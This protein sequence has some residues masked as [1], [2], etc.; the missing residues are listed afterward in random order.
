MT[1]S[2]RRS[3]ILVPLF[4]IPSSC[5]WGIGDIG[6]VGPFASWLVGA[7][8]RILQFLPLNEMAS[9]A[10]SP[11]SALS[12]MAIDPIFI[13]LP[14]VPDFRAVGGLSSLS[15]EER[16]RLEFARQSSRVEYQAIRPIKH[17]AL[18]LAFEHFVDREWSAGSTRAD[19]LREYIAAEAWWLDDYAVFRALH[20]REQARPW[21]EWPAE[22]RQRSQD[23]MTEVRR[24]LAGE[25][26]FHQYVQ[27]LASQQ[28]AGARR[29]A[30]AS[31]VALF[32]DVP[33]MVDLHSADVWA[34]QSS[35][36]LDRSV[37]VPPDAFSADGQDWGMPAYNWDVLQANR[38]GWLRERARRAATL[39]DGYRVDHLVGFY[40]T[41]S[42]QRSDRSQPAFAPAD[43]PSQL[44]LGEAV[45]R[46][47]RSAGAEVI[48]EDLGV[49]P[50][51][52]RA[53]L[54]LLG[55]PGYRVFR[56]ERRWH[57]PGWPF[58]DPSEYPAVSVATTGTHDTETL[59]AWW[60]ACQYDE[61]R[62]ALATRAVRQLLD[63]RDLV[64][65]SF[66]PEVRDVLL[67]ALLASGSNIALFPVQD[68]FGWRERINTPATVSD[69][70]WTYRLPWLSDQMS[71]APEAVERQER[72]RE[73][74]RHH[75]RL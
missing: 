29:A 72:L 58:V 60:D 46:V 49:I 27:W 2:L 34:H 54:A 40:R 26:R 47:F 8:Q 48:A 64:N 41:Y 39:F 50:L 43:Q 9:G 44:R 67:Q 33:F 24:S 52:V 61:R 56:W 45:L 69:N 73:W 20:D 65:E 62:A 31:G 30:A 75:N 32:G 25:I 57:E 63:G 19:S 4:S 16:G 38:F 53:S 21:W 7:G 37:G 1:T 11:Y 23:A 17:H 18:R 51:F 13:N 70:N 28:W 42:R 66:L 15:A 3:G 36:H 68:I 55:V 59:A 71:A 12:A 35:F 14:D 10:T 5:S 74:A 6:D 22:I